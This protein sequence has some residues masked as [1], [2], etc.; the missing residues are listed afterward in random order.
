MK[1]ASA[2]SGEAIA[3]ADD[4]EHRHSASSPVSASSAVV[5]KPSPPEQLETVA[6]TRPMR[7]A[8]IGDSNAVSLFEALRAELGDADDELCFACEGT[9]IADA[10]RQLN[11]VKARVKASE[12]SVDGILICTGTNEHPFAKESYQLLVEHAVETGLGRVLVVR[13]VFKRDESESWTVR[14]VSSKE[15]LPSGR[16]KRARQ[17][18]LSL[19]LPAGAAL[20]DAARPYEYADYAD[21]LHLTKECYA[22]VARKVLSHSAG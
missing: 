9:N 14:V 3:A 13:P 11:R 7:L 15:D 2:A 17:S 19:W 8:V 22:A 12:L 5:A 10:E 4:E 6:S 1:G 20:V 21:N 18:V 16:P